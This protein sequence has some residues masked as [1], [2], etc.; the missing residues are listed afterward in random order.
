MLHSNFN[1]FFGNVK[2]GTISDSMVGDLFHSEIKK[3]VLGQNK[4]EFILFC[5]L[6]MEI[7]AFG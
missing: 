7:H 4:M 1:S 5:Q 2:A 6:Q 3:S